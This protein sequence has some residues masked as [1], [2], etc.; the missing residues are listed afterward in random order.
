M[1]VCVCVCVCVSVC[2]TDLVCVCVSVHCFRG[3]FS[4]T[5]PKAADSGLQWDICQGYLVPEGRS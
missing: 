2:H 3:V 5:I 1:C 4:V